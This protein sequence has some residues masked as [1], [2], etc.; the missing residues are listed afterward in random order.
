LILLKPLS[1]GLQHETDRKNEAKTARN[2]YFL[3]LSIGDPS[4][5]RTAM[6]FQGLAGG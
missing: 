1:N 3:S 6:Q 4:R 5:D 2:P